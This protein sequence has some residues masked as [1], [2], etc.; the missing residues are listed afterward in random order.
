MIITNFFYV[1]INKNIPI[2]ELL[3]F[4]LQVLPAMCVAS[5]G[6]LLLRAASMVYAS[7][8]EED[9]GSSSARFLQK[10]YQMMDLLEICEHGPLL[11]EVSKIYF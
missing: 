8:T 6:F 5:V 1:R 7:I 11:S 10:K 4:F 9:E 2:K 3:L